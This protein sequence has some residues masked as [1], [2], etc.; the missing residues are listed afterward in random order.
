MKKEHF[1][2]TFQH[3]ID[4]LTKQKSYKNNRI[5]KIIT[6]KIQTFSCHDWLA[7]DAFDSLLTHYYRTNKFIIY[8]VSFILQFIFYTQQKQTNIL[9]HHNTVKAT[10]TCCLLWSVSSNWPG[11]TYSFSS[12]II[13]ILDKFAIERCSQLSNVT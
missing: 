6:F 2:Q 4:Q 13:I 3:A 9:D 1:W 7:L 8:N 5:S 10:A 12:T 11:N